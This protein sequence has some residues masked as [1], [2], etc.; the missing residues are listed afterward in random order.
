MYQMTDAAFTDA[1]GDCIHDH[2]V[3]GDCWFNGL[4]TRV[5]PSHAIELTSVF[6]DRKVA[7]VLAQTPGEAASVRQKQDLAALIHLCG[8]G[9]AKGFARQGLRLTPGQR[10]GDHDAARYLAA[11]NAMLRQFRQIAANE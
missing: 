3:A 4:Y 6:L 5:L 8:A 9:A 1:R 2:A 7:A 10:C 11:V